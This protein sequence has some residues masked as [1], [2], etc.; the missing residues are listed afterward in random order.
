M[1]SESIFLANLHAAPAF[2]KERKMH[3]ALCEGIYSTGT[4]FAL[5]H[6]ELRIYTANSAEQALAHVC[7]LGASGRLSCMRSLRSEQIKV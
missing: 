4:K 6:M 5:V 3:A 2:W 7:R 1:G